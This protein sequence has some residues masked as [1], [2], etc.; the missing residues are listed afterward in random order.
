MQLMCINILLQAKEH[1]PKG[2][3]KTTGNLLYH[4]ASK[5]KPQ[6]RSKIDI[7]VKYVA[8]GKIDTEIKLNGKYMLGNFCKRKIFLTL[9]IFLI[10]SNFFLTLS[11]IF[12]ISALAHIYVCVIFLIFPLYTCSF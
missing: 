1:T 11:K 8:E 7:V 10:L 4:I 2:I 3:P 9:D 6:I 5:S 12:F